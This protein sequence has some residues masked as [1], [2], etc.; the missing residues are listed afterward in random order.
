[1]TTL[2]TRLIA[3]FL[4]ATILPLV[5]TIWITTTLIDRSLGYSTTG[6]LDQLSRTLQSTVRHLYQRER[7]ALKQDAVSGRLTPTS[8]AVAD[9]RNWPDAVRAFWDSGE[10]ER[11][12]LSG[13]DGDHLDYL[14][15]RD[16]GGAVKGRDA[17]TRDLRGVRMDQLAAQLR[18]TRQVIDSGHGSGLR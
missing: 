17:F 9:A 5:A 15:R 18:E 1:M 2:R 13:S 3:A 14:R 7:D 12:R 16:E 11:F 4:A 6:E 10:Q 8:F